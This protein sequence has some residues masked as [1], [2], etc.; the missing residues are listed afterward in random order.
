LLVVLVVFAVIAPVYIWNNFDI[1][2]IENL[3]PSMNQIPRCIPE[4]GR[5]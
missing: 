4:G 2:S 1:K 5:R 3:D